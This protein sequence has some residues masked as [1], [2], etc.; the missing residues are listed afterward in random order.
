MVEA[1]ANKPE[2]P[3]TNFAINGQRVF[4]VTRPDSRAS[5]GECKRRE[6][7]SLSKWSI[8]HSEYWSPSITVPKLCEHSFA[9]FSLRFS[10]IFKARSLAAGVGNTMRPIPPSFSGDSCAA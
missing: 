8:S 9:L 5:A 3:V 7:P 2:L 4:A 1:N 6:G 10:H